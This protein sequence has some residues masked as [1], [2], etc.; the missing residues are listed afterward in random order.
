MSAG[1]PA[2]GAGK[3][4]ADILF[5]VTAGQAVLADN[6]LT[7][8]GPAPV[9]LHTTSGIGAGTTPL[10]AHTVHRAGSVLGKNMCLW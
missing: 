7:L 6:T 8:S 3:L 5:T 10:G 9:A 1:A 4:P 2:P